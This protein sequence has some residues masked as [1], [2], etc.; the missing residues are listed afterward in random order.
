MVLIHDK[1]KVYEFNEKRV[2]SCYIDSC[3][4]R[5]TEVSNSGAIIIL[6]YYET[7]LG[8]ICEECF[9]KRI[10]GGKDG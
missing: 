4:K 10:E 6:P 5:L 2:W 7:S 3:R 1:D 9:K 8:K